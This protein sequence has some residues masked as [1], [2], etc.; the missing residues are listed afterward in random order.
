[1]S[2]NDI[3]LSTFAIEK[4]KSGSVSFKNILSS[5]KHYWYVFPITVIVMLIGAFGY[6]K[7]AQPVYEI[8]ATL[9]IN[10]DKTTDTQPQ[11]SVLDKIDLPNSSDIT[12]NE[13]AKLKSIDLIR[14]VITKLQLATIYKTKVD[15]VPH[16]LYSAL[17][18]KFSYVKL[19]KDAGD[20]PHTIK[21]IVNND[22]SFTYLNADGGGV[23]YSFS[24]PVSTEIGTWKLDPSP[25]TKHYTN[26]AITITLLDTDKLAVAYQKLIDASLQDKLSSA[27]D[28]SIT[29]NN[30][31]RGKD[32]LNQLIFYY[33]N[34]DIEAKEKETQSTIEFIN[35][36]LDSLTG[37]LSHAEKNI[38][39]FKSSN[40]LTD[41]SSDSKFNLDNLQANDTKLNDLNVQLS[42][43]NGIENYI[44]SPQ[45]KDN[46]P[47]TLGITDPT[48]VSS[49]ERLSVLQL[50]RQKLLA[51]TPETNPDFEALNR[52][53][54]TTRAAI[55][56]NVQNI[57]SSLLNAR[58]KVQSVSSKVESSITSMPAQEREYVSIK[59]QQAI[60]ENLYIYLLQ[61]REEVSLKYATTV[62]NYRVIDN[63]YAGPIKWPVP[64]VIY[65]AAFLLG[66][67]LP[68]G[69]I[70]LKDITAGTIV[71]PDLIEEQT[72]QPIF[73]E[74][75]TSKVNEAIV[76]NNKKSDI[77]SEQFRTLR[78]KFHYIG[79]PDEK[80]K[81][82]LLTSSVANEGKS[83]VTSNLGVAL[84]STGKK[85]VILE[86]D[87]RKSKISETFGLSDDHLGLT[88]F[89]ESKAQL[90]AI[91]RPIV[92]TPM[93]DVISRGT[94]VTNPSELLE[95][96]QLRSLIDQLKTTYDYILVDSPPVHLVTDA[97][98]ISRF[99]QTTLYLIR[100]GFTMKSELKYIKGLISEDKLPNI[101]IIFNGINNKRYGYGYE[102]NNSYY[103]SK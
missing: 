30:K 29:D 101:Q 61:K 42:V 86:L 8:K 100:Q 58:Q 91:I 9:L 73:S 39:S 16:D 66:L 36:R 44:N 75:S 77:V 89:F 23:R 103:T 79:D 5:L 82:I 31:Q 47:A 11:Q 55:R 10:Q 81:V 46:V 28:L 34:S 15:G 21:I 49:I 56:E 65:A 99:T 57:K 98:I 18:F 52:Q 24:A 13:I 80:T 87:L 50:D 25:L 54:Q 40:Q 32:I 94:F 19:N 45:N 2:K 6:L 74:I 20:G 17:P 1:M 102:Y 71:D 26:S 92:A 22:N 62:K 93:L 43:I 48:L 85:T 35:Q 37:E 3:Q 51:T 4:G 59:R 96:D 41:I 69:F 38:E 76:I 27:V 84:A 7:F 78:S 97:L 63:S 14:E 67:I 64:N 33:N 90:D 68:M 83:F 72:N 53:I 88:D 95:N 70:Y 12:E 60:K